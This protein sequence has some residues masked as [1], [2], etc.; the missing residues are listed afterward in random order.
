MK[1]EEKQVMDKL[2]E[3]HNLFRLLPEYHGSDITEWVHHF[4]ALQNIIMSRV[5]VRSNPEMFTNLLVKEL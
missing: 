1:D 5:A 2:V 3:A 4:H